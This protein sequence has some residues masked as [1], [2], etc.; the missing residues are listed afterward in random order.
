VG[1]V[2]LVDGSEW[3]VTEEM[4]EEWEEAYPR[5]DVR[6]EL[7][8]LRQWNLSNPRKRK[9]PRGIRK[10]VTDWLARVQNSGRGALRGVA[11]D[12]S[13]SGGQPAGPVAAGGL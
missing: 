5:V 9:T 12:G 3:A 2:P 1:A 6:Q 7:R 8:S 13:G 10:H 11:G 4:V